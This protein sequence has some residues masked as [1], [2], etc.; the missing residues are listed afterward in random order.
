MMHYEI[1]MFNPL[2]S[3]IYLDHYINIIDGKF[4]MHSINDEAHA[5]VHV[6]DEYAKAKLYIRSKK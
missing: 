6:E 3:I 1:G 4:Y 2:L 5:N